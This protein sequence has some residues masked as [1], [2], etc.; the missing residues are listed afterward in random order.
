[1]D[2]RWNIGQSGVVKKEGNQLVHQEK[3]RTQHDHAEPEVEVR[4]EG[5]KDEY[6]GEKDKM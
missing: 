5:G 4:A 6:L 1:M 2:G 3:K